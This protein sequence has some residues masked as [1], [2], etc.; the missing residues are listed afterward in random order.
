M[1]VEF[2]PIDEAEIDAY[3]RKGEPLHG[4]FR[5]IEY[6]APVRHL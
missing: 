5:M 1:R 3:Y 6:L 2:G 4:L